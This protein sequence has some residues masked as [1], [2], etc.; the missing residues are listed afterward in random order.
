MTMQETN[1][2]TGEIRPIL[3][4]QSDVL[5]M[6]GVRSH[7]TLNKRI[8]QSGFPEPLKIDGI[9]FWVH[10]EVLEWLDER[11]KEARKEKKALINSLSN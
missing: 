8:Q 4:K 7:N 3:I 1:V 11:I 6:C 2:T 10:T 5:K 9:K